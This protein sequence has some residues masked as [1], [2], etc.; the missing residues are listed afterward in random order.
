M[1]NYVHN[2]RSKQKSGKY[3]EVPKELVD[4]V[5]SIRLAKDGTNN[6]EPIGPQ[7]GKFKARLEKTRILQATRCER[8]L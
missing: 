4:L 1:T 7:I 3:D 2:G 5:A 8:E 6:E